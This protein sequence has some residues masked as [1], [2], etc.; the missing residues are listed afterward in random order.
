MTIL[1]YDVKTIL[2]LQSVLMEPLQKILNIIF[3]ARQCS[4]H[5]SLFYFFMNVDDGIFCK[6]VSGSVGGLVPK[7]ILD[8]I[9][10]MPL[11]KLK[12]ETLLDMSI[13]FVQPTCPILRTRFQYTTRTQS[14]HKQQ[15]YKAMMCY[16][17]GKTKGRETLNKPYKQQILISH[18]NY[19]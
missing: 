13:Y 16:N 4:S 9:N 1:Y 7:E 10:S 14:R 3:L 6:Q 17:L 12:I 15:M 18:F 8:S 2:Q 19:F 11:L 5:C